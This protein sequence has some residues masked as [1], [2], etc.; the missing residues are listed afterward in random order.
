MNKGPIPLP[1]CVAVSLV[2]MMHGCARSRAHPES[3][4][5]L[6]AASR[7]GN[8]VRFPPGHPQLSRIRVAVVHVERVPDDEVVAP[9]KIELDPGRLS[10]V[11]LPVPGRINR[12]LVRL[13]DAVSVGQPVLSLESPD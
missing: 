6:A 10:R 2:M 8:V 9:G 3:E 1:C 13:G 5:S 4:P 12:V 7:S 11:A